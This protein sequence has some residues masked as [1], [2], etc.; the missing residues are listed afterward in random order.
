MAN[1]LM[2]NHREMVILSLLLHGELYGRDIRN[3][4]EQRTKEEIP[5]GSLYVTLDRM[6]DKGFIKAR[7]GESSHRRGGNRRKYYKLTGAGST[8]LD[9]AS[10]RAMTLFGGLAHG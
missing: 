3:R 8:A 1:E 7:L 4:Y 6:E 9:R 5:L 10:Q 2:P